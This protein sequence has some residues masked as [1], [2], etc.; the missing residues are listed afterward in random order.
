M[1]KTRLLLIPAL[2]ALP[3]SLQAQ[4]AERSDSS[5]SVTETVS[6]VFG[7][8]SGIFALFSGGGSGDGRSLDG[9]CAGPCARRASAR[10]V[11]ASDD[12]MLGNSGES[13]AADA[14]TSGRNASEMPHPAASALENASQSAAFHRDA[15]GSGDPENSPNGNANGPGH[16]ADAP[17]LPWQAAPAAYDADWLGP[18]QGGNSMNEFGSAD[19]AQSTPTTFQWVAP[20]AQALAVQQDVN[21]I[22]NPEPSTILLML[23]GLGTLAYARLRTRR[24][25]G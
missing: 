11:M 17:A 1:L 14:K 18:V 25:P 22:V 16:S 12:A 19:G 5:R 13:D 10:G 15:A 21:V 20:P 8:G 9:W 24:R 4:R 7:I 2:C 6:G 3:L 23:A